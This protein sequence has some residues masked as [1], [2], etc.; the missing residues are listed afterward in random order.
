MIHNQLITD[1]AMWKVASYVLK[2]NPEC[3]FITL[4]GADEWEGPP[5][6]DTG[7]RGD[8][9]GLPGMAGVE[10]CA[11]LLTSRPCRFHALSTDTQKIFRRLKLDGIKNVQELA[12]CILEKLGDPDPK[13]SC[14]EFLRQVRKNNMSTLMKNALMLISALGVWENDK[15]LPTSMCINYINMINSFVCRAKGEQGWPSSEKRLR[16][17]DD[18]EAEWKKQSSQLTDLFS[19]YKTFQRYAGLF[20]S[21][22]HLASDLLLGKQEQSLVFSKEVC[23]PYLLVG[24]E[25]DESLNVCLAIGIISK[26]ETTTRGIKKVERYMFCHKTFQEF[27]AALWIASKYAAEGTKLLCEHVK[28]IENVLDYS[29]LI[30][31]ICAL[32]PDA[33]KEFWWYVAEEVVEKDE[34]VQL[35]RE[36]KDVFSVSDIRFDGIDELQRLVLRC[37]REARIEEKSDQCYFCCPDI[38]ILPW[39]TSDEDITLLWN[40]T[41]QYS[42]I[43]C[44]FV[45]YHTQP[46]KHVVLSIHRLISSGCGLQMLVLMGVCPSVLD[47]HKHNKLTCLRLDEL[48]VDSLILPSTEEP[49]DLLL[50]VEGTRISEVSIIG[51]TLTHHGMEQLTGWL[52]SCS[53]LEN[54]Q[55]KKLSCS[56]HGS[57]C[58][59]PVLLDLQKCNRLKELRL[60]DLSV[61]GLLMPSQIQGNV[62]TDLLL[63]GVK[64]SA[65]SWRKFRALICWKSAATCRRD[66]NQ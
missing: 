51:V 41:Y 5:S 27:F 3:C 16:R 58:I 29:I 28:T 14:N 17:L 13:R 34:R 11:L 1:E 8:L 9:V 20:L 65:Q 36:G 61:E 44:L 22:G 60:Q 47:L 42:N 33:G 18:L 21:L 7:R 48:S 12:E 59:L 10:E 52:S 2:H 56:D 26:T 43:K 40:M 46:P 45:A 31:F 49:G 30:Q 54:L 55:L 57:G 50:P 23:K 38:L 37:M 66:E 53:S 64:M 24:D 25:N 15:S 63:F 35:H 39:N 19:R 4:D 62:N 6:S 32:C